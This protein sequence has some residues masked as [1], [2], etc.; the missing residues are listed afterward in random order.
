ML[1][2]DPIQLEVW[3]SFEALTIKQT[4]L[5]ETMFTVLTKNLANKCK[6]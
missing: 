1:Y 2:A 3:E 6:S 5:T 4:T